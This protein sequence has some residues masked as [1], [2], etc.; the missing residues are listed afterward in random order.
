MLGRD[1]P[2]LPP[3]GVRGIGKTRLSLDVAA[4]LLP[5][6]KDGVFFVELASIGEPD[7]VASTI[8][9]TLGY[10][11]MGSGSLIDGLKRFIKDQRMLLVLDN[12]EQ[13]LDAAPL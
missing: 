12:F 11:Q 7:L 2:L 9:T 8:G 6:F 10:T 3:S 1:I 4:R 13:V 5:E